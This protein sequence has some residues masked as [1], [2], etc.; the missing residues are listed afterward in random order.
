[1]LTGN[2]AQRLFYDNYLS[3]I[4]VDS[5]DSESDVALSTR[6]KS[7]YS[8]KVI[9]ALCNFRRYLHVFLFVHGFNVIISEHAILSCF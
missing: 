8:Y 4:L 5:D 2:K 1:M 6:R 7:E 9:V 3:L